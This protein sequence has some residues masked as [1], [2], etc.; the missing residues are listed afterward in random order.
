M[1]ASIVAAPGDSGLVRLPPRAAPAAAQP[2]ATAAS[3]ASAGAERGLVRLLPRAP[4]AGRSVRQAA[5]RSAAF[6]VLV[7]VDERRLWVVQGRDTLFRAPIAVGTGRVLRHGDRAWRFETP[8]S[9]RSVLAK[10]SN[11]VWVPPDWHYAELAADS[12]WT[13][14]PLGRGR[15]ARLPDGSRLEVRGDLVAHVRPDGGMEFIPEGEEVVFG[16]TLYMPPVGTARR[17]PGE[18][19]AYKLDLGNGYMLHGTPHKESI[20]QAATHGCIRL[21]DDAI[22]HLYRTVPV[23]TPVYI[24]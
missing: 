22:A 18:L 3:A 24:F 14:V 16:T 2:I 4:G 13:L 21:D 5:D 6:R 1:Q 11:P 10:Q 19:G 9:V 17:V 7:S 23:G 15:P 20:G 12:G 8:R